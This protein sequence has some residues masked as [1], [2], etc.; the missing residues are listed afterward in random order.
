M[1][2]RAAVSSVTAVTIMMWNV[3]TTCNNAHT[4]THK[5][6]WAEL[7]CYDSVH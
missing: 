1:C 2:K 4:C 5:H 7:P 3:Y 6:I